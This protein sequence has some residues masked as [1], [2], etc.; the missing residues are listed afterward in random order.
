V[1]DA[2]VK[3]ADFTVTSSTDEAWYASRRWENLS[4]AE[5]ARETDWAWDRWRIS[6]C[7]E[8]HG[9]HSWWLD[10]DEDDGL[11]LVCL[12]C[13]ADVNELYPDGTDVLGAELPLPDGQVL[14]IDGGATAL[15]APVQEWHGPVRARVETAYYPGGPWGGPEWDAWIVV[16]AAS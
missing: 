14:V 1:E 7:A 11:H 15:D 9:G 4:P 3:I 6:S 10:W 16:E 13:P 12:H 2:V 8:W 5:Q